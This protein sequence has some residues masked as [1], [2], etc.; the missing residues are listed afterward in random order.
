VLNRSR[1]QEIT[2]GGGGKTGRGPST[3][4]V[5]VRKKVTLNKPARRRRD[6][7]RFRRMAEIL[8]KLAESRQRNE[9][10]QQRLAEAKTDRQRA[11]ELAERKRLEEA[12]AER[13]PRRKAAAEAAALEDRRGKPETTATTAIPSRPRA[14]RADK[15][16]ANKGKTAHR[17]SH[18]MVAGVEDDDNTSALRRP[19]APVRLR[20]CAPQQQRQLA[21][22]AEAAPRSLDQSRTGTGFERRPRRWCARS[23]SAMRSPW[24]TS[25]RSW[26]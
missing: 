26:R 18:A 1:K 25:R 4:D 9:A 17:G 7:S 12:E 15:N 23:P 19:V 24:P 5:V 22:Q 16:A 21:R 10:E 13:L 11:E 2:V 20:S 6:R 8:R 14:R 3:I